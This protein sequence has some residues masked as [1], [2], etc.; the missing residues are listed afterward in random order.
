[1]TLIHQI[2]FERPLQ[3]G[4][5]LAVVLLSLVAWRMRRPGRAADRAL[6][7]GIAA[8]IAL[9]IVQYLV[10]TDR[11]QITALMTSLARASDVEDIDTIAAALDRDYRLDG[12]DRDAVIAWVEATLANVDVDQ[13]YI[14]HAEITFPTAETATA[15][16]TARCELTIGSLRR[17][18]IQSLWQI[19]LRRRAPGHWTITGVDPLK[20]G[21]RPVNALGDLEVPPGL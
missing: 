5:V 16:V 4:M 21:P 15:I 12:L 2:L 6:L 3:L 14:A 9:M 8:A 7:I 19:D 1:M 17:R 10:K 11:E 13:P 20:I 18:G